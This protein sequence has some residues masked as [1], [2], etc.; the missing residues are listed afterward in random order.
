MGK[1]LVTKLNGAVT[2][3]KL[4]HLGE[5]VV[6]VLNDEENALFAQLILAGEYSCDHAHMLGEERVEANVKMSINKWTDLKS[7]EKGTYNIHLYDKYKA[8]GVLIKKDVLDTKQLDFL[9]NCTQFHANFIKDA[10]FDISVLIKSE[11]LQLINLSGNI[12]GDIASLKSNTGLT[13]L[14]LS[15]N[16]TGDIASLK[17]NTGLTS[18]SLR[19]NITGDIASLKSNTGLTILSLSGNITGDI[20]SLKSNTGLTSLSLSGNH[21]VT[22]KAESLPSSLSSI[23]NKSFYNEDFGDISV[24]CPNLTYLYLGKNVNGMNNKPNVKWTNRPSSY[25]TIGIFDSPNVDSI[26][27]M[28]QDQANCQSEITPSTPEYLKLISATGTRTSASDAA[29]Q[30]LQSKGYTVSITPA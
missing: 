5:T 2:N 17:S 10:H 25:K 9:L 14:S 6:S 1:C 15:G 23:N 24:V 21:S 4:L 28:L 3:D 13:S 11:K 26:D 29:V 18:L 19:G 7:I 27:K 12:T 16:I 22:I 30:T 8:S 20:A